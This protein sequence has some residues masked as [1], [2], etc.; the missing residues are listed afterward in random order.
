V[1]RSEDGSLHEFED[2]HFAA[3]HYKYLLHIKEPYLLCTHGAFAYL[4]VNIGLLRFLG[5]SSVSFLHSSSSSTHISVKTPS[6]RSRQF[7]LGVLVIGYFFR[8]SV[9]V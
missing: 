1:I 4:Q 7:Y 6:S 2:V 8:I 9:I 3:G 5:R